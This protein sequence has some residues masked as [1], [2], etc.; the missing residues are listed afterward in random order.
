MKVFFEKKATISFF[1]KQRWNLTLLLGSLIFN[2]LTW[3]WLIWRVKPSDNLI[4][5]SYNIY[6]GIDSFG[7]WQRIFYVPIFGLAVIIINYI[8]AYFIF[9][10]DSYLSLW[11]QVIAFIIQ[12]TIILTTILLVINYI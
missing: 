8:L 6:F 5:L 11:L 12:A 1:L 4:P 9:L 10:K 3:L 2:I 7:A